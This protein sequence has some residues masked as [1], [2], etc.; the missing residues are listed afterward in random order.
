MDKYKIR[1]LIQGKE[2]EFICN[3]SS[4]EFM[5]YVDAIYNEF[6]LDKDAEIKVLEK[7]LI[8]KE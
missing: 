1:L 3:N 2:F 7:S 5:K 8:K 4:E 6:K